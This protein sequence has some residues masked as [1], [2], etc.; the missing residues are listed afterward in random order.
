[1][2][3]RPIAFT[4]SAPFWMTQPLPGFPGGRFNGRTQYSSASISLR[5]L[6]W[7]QTW[8]PFVMTSAPAS[9][10]SRAIS[11]VS[12]AP[13]AAFSPLTTTRSISLSRFTAGT[14][15]A[16]AC[17]PGLPTT[18]PTNRTLIARERS[19]TEGLSRE[20]VSLFEVPVEGVDARIVL[21]HKTVVLVDERRVEN[22]DVRRN[23]AGIAVLDRCD[24]T[25]KGREL[26]G[27]RVDGRTTRGKARVKC[28]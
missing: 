20:R 3:T 24:P 18:S 10:I 1:M 13:P 23:A 26:R 27:R 22:V 14:S 11:P 9:W 16:T 7:S 25:L 4:T 19:A 12:P 8:F 21:G 28:R 15:A 2:K 5:K 6:R 17:R